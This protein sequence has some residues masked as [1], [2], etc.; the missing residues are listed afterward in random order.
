MSTE[1]VHNKTI[2]GLWLTDIQE[3]DVVISTRTLLKGL[4]VL[5]QDV[6][7]IVRL[8]G[9]HFHTQ[10]PF[11]FCG[12][13]F[14][15]VSLQSS[16]HQRLELCVQLLDLGFVIYITEIELAGQCNYTRYN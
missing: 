6:F 7:I 8:H 13:R 4:E 5:C 10:D 1:L 11:A 12:K 3:T 2:H 15:Y 9:A 16:Q 14:E